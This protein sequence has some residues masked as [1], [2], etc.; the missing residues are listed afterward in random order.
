MRLHA[1]WATRRGGKVPR[2]EGPRLH[3]PVWGEAHRERHEPAV[4]VKVATYTALRLAREGRTWLAQT[5]VDV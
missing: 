4:D 3:G 2:F 5:V 1:W